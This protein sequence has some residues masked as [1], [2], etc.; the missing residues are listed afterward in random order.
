MSTVDMVKRV[1]QLM[2]WVAREQANHNEREKRRIKIEQTVAEE[3]AAALRLANG[4][5][6]AEGGMDI[7]SGQD[8]KSIIANN[9]VAADSSN[10]QGSSTEA[11]SSM[12]NGHNHK[13][14]DSLSRSE[15]LTA[16]LMEELMLE[17]ISF[18]EKY[19]AQ[20]SNNEL[21]NL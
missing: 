4:D 11:N 13:P 9:S 2:E 7:D 18:Q 3:A 1:R 12:V 15:K 5:T 10:A 19:A 6:A 21:M 17:L 16:S 8:S 20:L 14:P